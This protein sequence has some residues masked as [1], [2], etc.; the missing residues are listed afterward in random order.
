MPAVKKAGRLIPHWILAMKLGGK[1]NKWI[2]E[3]G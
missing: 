1:M 2:I 3:N